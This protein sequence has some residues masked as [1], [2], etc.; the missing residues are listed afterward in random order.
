MNASQNQ[1][2]FLGSQILLRERFV[3]QINTDIS[4]AA[5]AKANDGLFYFMKIFI[6][7]CELD[8]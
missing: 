4:C 8:V 7:N 1:A 3:L 5:E 6:I 2:S